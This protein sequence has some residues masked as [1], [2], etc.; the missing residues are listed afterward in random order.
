ME[1]SPEERIELDNALMSYTNRGTRFEFELALMSDKQ[2]DVDLFD[3]LV[4]RDSEFYLWPN[5]DE[6]VLY[7]VDQK[8]LRF[9]DIF[10]VSN[11]KGDIPGFNKD[12]RFSAA[13]NKAKFVEVA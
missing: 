6:E 7:L 9:C 4:T 3:T 13:K 1:M 2:N 10:K 5:D 12:D 8:P 11:E